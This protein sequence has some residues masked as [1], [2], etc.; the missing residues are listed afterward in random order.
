MNSVS[1][2]FGLQ[3]NTE[4]MDR[5]WAMFTIFIEHDALVNNIIYMLKTIDYEIRLYDG[6]T[7]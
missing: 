4:L 6:N 7:W 1:W 3:L 5:N 2:Y